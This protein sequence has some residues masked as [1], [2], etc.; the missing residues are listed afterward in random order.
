MTRLD[1]EE[2]ALALDQ[3]P[4]SLTPPGWRRSDV[5]GTIGLVKKFRGANSTSAEFHALLSVAYGIPILYFNLYRYYYC[6]HS[7]KYFSCMKKISPSSANGMI[8]PKEETL[9]L[10]T[11]NRQ[12]APGLSQTMHPSLEVPFWFL[13]PC[14]TE[15]FLTMTSEKSL[16]PSPGQIVASWLGVIEQVF[17][18]PLRTR[19]E[20]NEAIK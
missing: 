10:A 6:C 11:G 15:Q 9:S 2:F 13:H 16:P 12:G 18:G 14:Q 4:S 20:K 5:A 1:S 7:H 19:I 17:V 8:M 3:L